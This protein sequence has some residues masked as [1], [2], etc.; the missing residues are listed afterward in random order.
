GRNAGRRHGMLRKIL[1]RHKLR[2]SEMFRPARHVAPH[3]I[4]LQR[5]EIKGRG[6]HTLRLE[7]RAEQEGPPAHLHARLFGERLDAHRSKIGVGGSELV[8]EIEARHG[9]DHGT[10]EKRPEAA[11]SLPTS[12]ARASPQPE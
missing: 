12:S 5:K 9:P 4:A 1:W 11:F 3:V 2:Q 6:L 8:P 7:D 10:R